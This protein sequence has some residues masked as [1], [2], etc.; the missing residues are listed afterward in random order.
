METDK[1]N[2]VAGILS[3]N[4]QNTVI[5]T[6]ENPDGD[7]IGS[8]LGLCQFL[9]VCGYQNISVICPDDYPSFL[10]WMPGND[11]VIIAFNN[12]KKAKS[13]IGEAGLI[14]CIDFNDVER[15]GRL[16][17]PLRKSDAKTILIDH[18]PQPADGFD[19]VFSYIN[20]SSTAEIVYKL[21]KFIDQARIDKNIATCLFTGIMTDTGSF[22]YG[23]N[24]PDT[25]AICAEL[26][27]LGINPE[28]IHR[29]VYDTYSFE[30]MK[31]LG[32]C[33][34]EKLTIIPGFNTAYI[35]L[36]QKDLEQFNYQEGDTEGV[37][38]YAL[39]IRNIDIAALFI[40]KEDHVKISLRSIGSIDVNE[41][42]RKFF[43]G[44][45]H[46]NAAG[47]KYY[48]DIDKT[49]KYFESAVG[50]YRKGKF[51]TVQTLKQ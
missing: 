11:K 42:A 1:L 36:T 48:G 45:G 50:K 9:R 5:V 44:G 3:D 46:A 34:S 29:L 35:C 43:N 15:T 33:L 27:K 17:K 22:S 26:V 37:V 49:I 41:F 18:H 24:N 14:F 10:K 32:Y 28:S 23:C 2:K 4:T 21:L 51:K 6:H 31:L 8:S 30:R 25:F 20:V 38:N 12:F 19:L 16:E 47:G 39:S 13:I 40:E 7:A